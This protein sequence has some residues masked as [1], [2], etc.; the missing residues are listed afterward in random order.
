MSKVYSLH[1]NMQVF[2]SDVHLM[3]GRTDDYERR[4][5]VLRFLRQIAS[6]A[7]G[8]WIGGDLFDFW[9]EWKHAIPKCHFEILAELRSLTE[10]GIPVHMIPGN[11]DFALGTFFQDHVGITLHPSPCDIVVEGVRIHWNHGDGVAPSDG[12]YRFLKRI[13]HNSFAQFLFRW[14]HPDIA[15]GIALAT[16]KGSRYKSETVGVP[17]D[18]EYDDY[19]RKVL[20]TGNADAVVMGHTHLPKVNRV[21]NGWHINT[22]DFIV[23]R[24]YAVLEN[25]EWRI[26]R[27]EYDSTLGHNQIRKKG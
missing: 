8:L 9:F 4:D 10:K 13:L 1:S 2:F 25:K 20:E 17:P 5:R 6:H 7:D 19:A 3:S 27:F 21:G 14:I 18:E 26:E 24:T 11:H 15:M 23:E 22:G 16:S 12:G